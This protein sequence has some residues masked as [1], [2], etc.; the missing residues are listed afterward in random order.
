[1]AL[2]VGTLYQELELDDR[3]W[4]AGLSKVSR[5]SSTAGNRAGSAFGSGMNRG[6]TA[7]TQAASK[8][9]DGL[10][11]RTVTA[12]AA[13]GTALKGALIGAGIAAGV[14]IVAATRAAMG[15]IS[16][17][18]QA[19]SN[20]EQASGALESVLGKGSKAMEKWAMQ[21][22]KIGL[23]GT[24]AANS[25]TLL[26]TQLKNSGMAA[27]EAAN[28]SKKLVTLGADLAAAFGG[29]AAEAVSSISGILKGEFDSIEKYGISINETM[30]K[31]EAVSSGI[32]QADVDPVKVQSALAG[33]TQAN[34]KLAEVQ[35]DGKATAGDLEAAQA[36]VARA[37]DALKKAMAGSVP[38]LTQQQKQAAALNLAW[39]QSKDVQGQARRE[40]DTYAGQTARAAAEMENFKVQV[41]DAFRPALTKLIK[42][43]ADGLKD[44]AK[45]VRKHMPEIREKMNELADWII[46]NWPKAKEKIGEFVTYLYD[47]RQSI[48]DA[49]KMMADGVGLVVKAI[50]ELS[51][52][53]NAAPEP[54]Q[55][56]MLSVGTGG[57]YPVFKGYQA[58]EHRND[59][60]PALNM[61]PGGGGNFDTWG[62]K[63]KGNR[64]TRATGEGRNI[65]ID[66]VIV[67]ATNPDEFARG[68]QR[69]S[70]RNALRGGN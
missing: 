51:D 23:S 29:T 5:E 28:K 45:W 36:G 3:K 40:Q 62:K 31:A 60:N 42:N 12:G 39:K 47:N 70:R 46:E 63:K 21:Q 44:A 34:E 52:I 14:A 65:S 10:E 32:V 58:W 43:F 22:A 57:I 15:F 8:Q 1:M 13:I 18:V 53:Y 4:R 67:K 33:V 6:L 54:L 30:L 37:N 24:D 38:Q 27:D 25:A 48:F 55:F 49:L 26:V 2:N 61:D 17:G 16:S 68:M 19:S 35:K 69:N 41:G 50:K 11:R 64:G 66:K 20:W 9:V 59:P 56:A 7:G